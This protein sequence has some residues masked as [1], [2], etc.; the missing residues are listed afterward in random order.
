M[1]PSNSYKMA[2][3]SV[4]WLA[5]ALGCANSRQPRRSLTLTDEH[6]TAIN[7]ALKA[8]H[9]PAPESLEITEGGFLVATF[10][11]NGPV[12]PNSLEGFATG[13]LLAIREAMLPF[14]VV[15]N[16]RVTLN[17]PSP[18]TGLIRRYGNA[19][20]IEGDQVRWEPA[21]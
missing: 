9:Y 3:I 5:L 12:T 10:Q 16:Y 2:L 14:K 20:F 1:R 21:N 4:C 8:K 7:K 6:R 11:I 17:G 18:G 13:S 15:D 19:R